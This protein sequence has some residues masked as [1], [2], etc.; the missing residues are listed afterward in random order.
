MPTVNRNG[1]I[2][3]AH[4]ISDELLAAIM[5]VYPLAN[6]EVGERLEDT[7]GERMYLCLLHAHS[8]TPDLYLSSP[9]TLQAAYEEAATCE[10]CT[11]YLAIAPD[12]AEWDVLRD[13]LC[14]GEYGHVEIYTDVVKRTPT[15][16]LFNYKRLVPA[17]NQPELL[18]SW[19]YSAKH[20]AD[21]RR[22]EWPHAIYVDE[23]TFNAEIAKRTTCYDCGARQD[24]GYLAHHNLWSCVHCLPGT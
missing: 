19:D 18:S 22:Y 10:T 13:K 12:M 9:L 15:H 3:H 8:Y 24:I 17:S 1:A 7:R 2:I 16:L 23:E 21:D 20:I 6:S 5:P 14:N 11:T 4:D